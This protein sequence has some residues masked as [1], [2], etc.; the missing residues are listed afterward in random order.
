M[1]KPE[2]RP[3]S[4]LLKAF[5]L[6]LKFERA[7]RD[8]TIQL[9][10]DEGLRL[11]QQFLGETSLAKAARDDIK[12]YLRSLYERGLKSSTISN[13]IKPLKVFYDWLVGEED[14]FSRDELLHFSSLCHYLTTRVR[15]RNN[16]SRY[17]M[18][19]RDEIVKLRER[20]AGEK[21]R[22][23]PLRTFLRDRDRKSTRL[24]S[25]HIPLSR[26]PSSA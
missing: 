13:R 5:R 16:G 25:S 21:P 1:A 6:H 10:T 26:M 15:I 2:R 11:F 7:C 17:A 3:D 8:R 18:P 23:M 12:N 22:H 19:Y 20:L 24:N 14:F 4:D 9:Y